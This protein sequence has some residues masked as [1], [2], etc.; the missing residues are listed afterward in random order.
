MNDNNPNF[1]IVKDIFLY[2]PNSVIF[3]C[4]KFTAIGFDE[5]V[6]CYEVTLPE[7]NDIQCFIFQDL[8]ISPIPNTINVVSNGTYYITVRSP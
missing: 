7:I 2:G 3:E 6:F 5:H 4:G 1:V 8:L